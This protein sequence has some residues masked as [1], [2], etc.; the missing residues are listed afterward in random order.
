M[1]E[2]TPTPWKI[3]GR[4]M[5]P[6]S[7]PYGILLTGERSDGFQSSVAYCA[8]HPGVDTP[9]AEANA[10][11]IIKAVNNHDMLVKAIADIKQ[12]TLNGSVCDDVAWFGPGETLHDFCESVL[13]RVGNAREPS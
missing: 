13:D 4:K 10:A 8:R 5:K 2:H 12:A 9:T 1:T 3:S 11:F 7:E 6:S